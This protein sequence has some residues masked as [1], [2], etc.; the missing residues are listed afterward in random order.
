[1][2]LH[3]YT[4]LYLSG[5][6]FIVLGIWAAI[7]YINMLDEIHDS[8]DDG[9]ENTKLLVINK[10]MQDTSLLHKDNFLESNYR[11]REIKP[12][13]SVRFTDVYSDTLLYTQNEKDFEPFRMLT[14]VFKM[15]N[16]DKY[17]KLRVISSTVEEDDL[18]EDLLYSLL[19]LYAILV[20]SMVVINN[21]LLRRIWKSFYE[22]IEKLR[23]YNIAEAKEMEFTPTSVEEFKL[24]QR[25]VQELI[26]SNRETFEAQKQF[27]ENAA[28]E[29]Q[30]PL[31]ISI[32]KLELMAEKDN[33]SEAQLQKLGEVVDS[34]ERLTRLNKSL[35]LLS[36][37]ENRQFPETEEI[38]LNGLV[39]SLAGE[40]E[41]FAVFKVIRITVIENDTCTITMNKSLAEIL[42][43]NLLKN[44]VF[45]TGEKGVV[46]IRIN[47]NSLIVENSGN[48]PL[49]SNKIFGRFYKDS[50][51]SQSTG[52]GLAIVNSIVDLYGFR[53]RYTFDGLHG[54]TV[55]F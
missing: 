21:F 10:T 15:P 2:K 38:A 9:L 11:I 6:L 55:H 3:N 36:K 20:V 1:M 43:M 53:I 5:A 50:A 45:H 17:Y 42:V 25:T 18:I 40:F 19:A 33:F 23:G 14:S 46:S 22:T 8:I 41:E 35:L 13:E 32:N 54:F 48:M 47:K 4:V 24:L 31:A 51:Q 26:Q 12:E 7:F 39:K 49:D 52:L 37:I 29:L 34:L 44:A 30:T 27:I 16:T 28:H